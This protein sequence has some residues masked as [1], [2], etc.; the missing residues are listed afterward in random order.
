MLRLEFFI[1]VS[2][3]RV[4]LNGDDNVNLRGVYPIKFDFKGAYGVAINWSDGHFADIYSFEIL[5]R[6]A[7]EE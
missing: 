7:T 6:I 1:L 4:L 5:K 2:I 3:G